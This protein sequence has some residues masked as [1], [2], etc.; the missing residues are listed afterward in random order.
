MDEAPLTVGI[1]KKLLSE[2][3]MESSKNMK[4]IENNLK[5]EIKK[6]E[7]HVKEYLEI[8]LGEVKTD[9]NNIKESLKKNSQDIHNIKKENDRGKRL[10]NILLFKIPE[11]ESNSMDLKLKIKS[12][13]LDSCKVDISNS[14][15]RIYRIGKQKQNKIRPILIALTSFDKKMEIM[16]GKKQHK[17]NLELADDYSPE[18]LQKRRELVPVMRKLRDLNYTNTH[19]KEDK[20][21]VDGSECDEAEWNRLINARNISTNMATGQNESVV[22]GNGAKR[23]NSVSPKGNT[24]KK[25]NLPQIDLDHTKP[26]TSRNY[27]QYNKRPPSSPISKFLSQRAVAEASIS[28]KKSSEILN[29]TLK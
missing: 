4:N 25:P 1:L 29:E 14:I 12:L 16:W 20:L 26:E 27:L 15:D 18:V 21:F 19:I 11:N 7:T 6:S 5:E 17:A 8:Q 10:R 13:I 9:V 22:I 3:N 28:S 2:Q 24:T 23:K